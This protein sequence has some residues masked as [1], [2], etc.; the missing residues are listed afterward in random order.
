MNAFFSYL[1]L[2]KFDF[3]IFIFFSSS[4]IQ[5]MIMTQLVED[6]VCLNHLKLDDSF[7]ANFTSYPDSSET[8]EILRVANSFK[9]WQ[10]V[11]HS[12]PSLIMSFF[13]GYWLGNYPKHFKIFII[14]VFIGCIFKTLVVLINLFMFTAPW[15]ALLIAD[16]L[17]SFC[18][19]GFF[20]FSAIY[21]SISWGTP[22]HLVIVRFA[23]IEF[24]VKIAILGSSYSSGL[25]LAMDPWIGGQRK[26]FVGVLLINLSI[27]LF[28]LIY[29]IF[30]KTSFIVDK[31]P[32]KDD[33]SFIEA[34]KDVFRLSRAK[35]CLTIFAIKRP[36]HGRLRLILL[37]TSGAICNAAIN[38][39]DSIA[40]QFA[41]RVYGLT[42]E[43][44]TSMLTLVYIP[45]AIATPITP[46]ILKL[47]DLSDSSIAILGCLSLSIFFIVRGIF[48]SLKGYIA[49]YVM[50][51][52]ARLSM[53]A[54]RSLILSSVDSTESA[55]IF[56]LSTASEVF[57]G[58]AANLM[59]TS[60]FS[61]T[62]A[63][64]PGAVMLLVGLIILFPLAVS[65]W[66]RFGQKQVIQCI[67][68]DSYS[69]ETQLRSQNVITLSDQ[70]TT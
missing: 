42:E 46:S 28:G 67:S 9:N 61:L 26:N 63:H 68:S 39:E 47:L 52:F 55:Q 58:L 48:L 21:S 2:M 12:I 43:S 13:I 22:S 57:V 53:V 45:L 6:K 36:N 40:Y 30:M 54:I 25:I 20:L 11:F 34:V 27:Y 51:T 5:D 29:A 10:F 41:Q 37:V 44:Y 24:F 15:W 59:Y 70:K 1:H 56:T 7:C 14:P 60:V 65:C 31:N 69:V 23:V 66:I 50:G 64:Q 17:Y 32:E 8:Q 62:I 18:G 19:G 3:C 38:S 4:V 35:K 33:A 16:S 49:G